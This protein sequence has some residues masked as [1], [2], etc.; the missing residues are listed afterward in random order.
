MAVKEGINAPEVACEPVTNVQE[1]GEVILHTFCCYISNPLSL[2]F[3]KISHLFSS[4]PPPTPSSLLFFV[5]F[6]PKK[7]VTS[8]ALM[9]IHLAS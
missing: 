4:I 3:F 7:H 1:V 5:Q 2:W 6:V 9:R 8:L